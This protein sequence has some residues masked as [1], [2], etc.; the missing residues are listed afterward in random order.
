MKN[1][2]TRIYGF[3]WK[4][5]NGN[6]QA[7]YENDCNSRQHFYNVRQSFKKSNVKIEDMRTKKPYKNPYGK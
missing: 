2:R 4:N 5:P 7:I 3:C 1:Q 6:C